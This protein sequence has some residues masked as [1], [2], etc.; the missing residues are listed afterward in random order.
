LNLSQN[1]F[2]LFGLEVGFNLDRAALDTAFRE[3]QKEYHPDRFAHKSDA[4]QRQAVQ[5]S[6][7]LNT[8][9]EALK[10]PLLR[11]QYLLSLQGVPTGE[12]SRKQLPINFLMQQM[13]LREALAEAPESSD[14]FATLEALESQTVVMEKS[15][16]DDFQ[17]AYAAGDL[18]S[19]EESVRKL[20]FLK[21]LLSEI[22]AMEDRLDEEF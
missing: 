11:A 10:S 19:A 22:E 3:L 8:A 18:E 4:E 6:T 21:K 15:C 20:Q 9:Y 2:E 1:Y 16:F 12:E 13:E 5:N 7:H 17:S 14:P